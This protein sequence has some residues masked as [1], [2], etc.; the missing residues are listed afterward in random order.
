MPVPT[1]RTGGALSR[2][3]TILAGL[4]LIDARRIVFC[5]S[6]RGFDENSSRLRHFLRLSAADAHDP[7]AERAPVTHWRLA[8][9]GSHTFRSEHSGQHLS[10]QFRE[11]LSRH[12][13]ARGPTDH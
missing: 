7:A 2:L 1:M 9:V 3:G 13:R 12:P 11:F 6:D 10:R 4:L 5:A 8:D